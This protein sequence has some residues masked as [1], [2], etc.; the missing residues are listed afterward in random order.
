MFADMITHPYRAVKINLKALKPR[1]EVF[2]QI[3]KISA[4][5]GA[6]VVD[7]YIY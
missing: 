2:F 7:K 5:G 3:Q 1:G 4:K 6:R